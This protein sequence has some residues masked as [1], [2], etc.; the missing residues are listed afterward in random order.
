MNQPGFG[1]GSCGELPACDEGVSFVR[2][3]ASACTCVNCYDYVAFYTAEQECVQRG[4]RPD[5]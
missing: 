5:N 1:G 4:I 2:A 3:P